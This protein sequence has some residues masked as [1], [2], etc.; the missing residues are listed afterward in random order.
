MFHKKTLVTLSALGLM[1]ISFNG[2]G[3]EPI[4]SKDQIV[5]QA[6]VDACKKSDSKS[7]MTETFMSRTETY[8]SGKGLSTFDCNNVKL[9]VV[10]DLRAREDKELEE[11]NRDIEIKK[12]EIQNLTPR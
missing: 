3:K 6:L 12:K 2:C 7:C 8:C 10:R 9:E 4:N 1:L 5:T 11:I